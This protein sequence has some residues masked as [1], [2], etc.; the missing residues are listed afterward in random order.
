VRDRT[1]IFVQNKNEWLQWVLVSA[2]VF[3]L[4]ENAAKNNVGVLSRKASIYQTLRKAVSNSD[5]MYSDATIACITLAATTEARVGLLSE[6]QKH[7]AAAKRLIIGRGDSGRRI[8]ITTIVAFIWIGTGTDTFPDSG[9]L[10]VAI[11]SFTSSLLAFHQSRWIQEDHSAILKQAMTPIRVSPE[12][13]LPAYI[14]SRRRAFHPLSPLRPFVEAVFKDQSVG[15]TRNHMA[16]LWVL[17]RILWNACY[18]YQDS[19]SFLD[20]LYMLVASA[21]LAKLTALTVLFMIVDCVARL[22]M[23]NEESHNTTDMILRHKD[24]DWRIKWLWEVVKVVEMLSLL[25][26]ETREGILHVLSA[27][28]VE[29]ETNREAFTESFLDHIADDIRSGWL[30]ST[31]P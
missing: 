6:A 30:H 19:I 25:L 26:K 1:A 17:N 24:G 15:E 8:P 11:A 18:S 31:R 21:D 7:L 27:E 13:L 3:L 10:E 20:R 5:T 14:Q 29:T 23:F 4:G 28:L 2:E 9:S 16:I 22:G 12:G